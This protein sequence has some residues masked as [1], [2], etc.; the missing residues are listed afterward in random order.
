MMQTLKS[1]NYSDDTKKMEIL[2]RLVREGHI[3]LEEAF[4][5]CD[6]PRINHII[7]EYPAPKPYIVSDPYRVIYPPIGTSPGYIPG[8]TIN[9]PFTGNPLGT[10]YT[11]TIS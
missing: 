6:N 10:Y 7:P 2:S 8:H 4:E 11:T 1:F 5:L 9:S 3:T